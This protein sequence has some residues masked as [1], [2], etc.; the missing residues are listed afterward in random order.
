MTSSTTTVPDA[1]RLYSPAILPD[2]HSVVNRRSIT[3]EHII[4]DVLCVT[5]HPMADGDVVADNH[6]G[7]AV[8]D[9]VIRVNI[10]VVTYGYSTGVSP[11]HHSGPDTGAFAYLNVADNV[12]TKREKTLLLPICLRSWP[13]RR[14]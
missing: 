6:V 8:N 9:R 7:V 10:G 11:Y 12:R 4:G 3:N 5:H 13:T 1:R 2:F 14:S